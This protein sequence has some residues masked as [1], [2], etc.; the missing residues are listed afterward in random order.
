VKDLY[1]ILEEIKNQ[2][3]K[4]LGRTSVVALKGF[5]NGYS[6]ARREIGLPLTEQE[7]DFQGF[8]EWLNPPDSPFFYKKEDS[9]DKLLILFAQ[10]E[11]KALAAFFKKLERFKNR[12]KLEKSSNSIDVNEEAR[13]ERARKRAEWRESRKTTEPQ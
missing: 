12:D 2:P 1:D 11:S 7:Q 5:I 9:W 6:L 8:Q 13:A 3:S 4:Y 10:D